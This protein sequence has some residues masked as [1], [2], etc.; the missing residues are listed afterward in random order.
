MDR[1]T[2][3]A[4]VKRLGDGDAAAFD[5]VYDEYRARIYS[6]LVRLSR[7]RDV[8]EDFRN[9][10]YLRTIA[11]LTTYEPDRGCADRI[12]ERCHARIA[13]RKRAEALPSPAA[14][15]YCRRILEPSLVV[16]VCAVFLCEVLRRALLLYGF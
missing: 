6:F 15:R 5:T 16:V 10:L 13:K 11:G 8:A 2:E 14:A 9:D 12:R 4:L 7:R 3:L 1:E